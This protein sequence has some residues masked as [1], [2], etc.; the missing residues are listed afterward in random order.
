MTP[1]Q[2]L[3]LLTLAA[4]L[5]GRVQTVVGLLRCGDPRAGVGED[6]GYQAE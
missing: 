2:L 1:A 6:G 5:A 3:D 4:R